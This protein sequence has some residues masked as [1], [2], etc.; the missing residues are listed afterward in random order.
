MKK[1]DRIKSRLLTGVIA[2]VLGLG[3]RK[4]VV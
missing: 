4:S 3:D 2:L 1:A